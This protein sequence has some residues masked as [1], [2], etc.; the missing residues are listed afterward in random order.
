MNLLYCLR[1][2]NID[3]DLL[4][5]KGLDGHDH[6]PRC[7]SACP[8]KKFTKVTPLISKKD[9][10][11]PIHTLHNSA[12]LHF[13]FTSPFYAL[14]SIKGRIM[15]YFRFG[16]PGRKPSSRDEHEAPSEAGEGPEEEQSL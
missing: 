11:R 12:N 16:D 5:L 14:V 7:R 9:N 8:G 2:V 10:N 3:L 15:G 1:E 6:P 4:L 13:T